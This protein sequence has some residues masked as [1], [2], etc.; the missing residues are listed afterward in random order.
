MLEDAAKGLEP[1]TR[2]LFEVCRMRQIPIFTFINK[3]DR[4]GRDPLS[5]LDEIESEL[6]LTPWAVNWPIGSGEQFRGVIDRR[7]RE[8]ILFTRAA[9]GRQSEER[10]LALN[11]PELSDLVE[12]ELLEQAVE[13]LELLEALCCVAIIVPSIALFIYLLPWWQAKVAVGLVY[14]PTLYLALGSRFILGLHY[15]SH[16]PM[17][18][19]W[20]ADVPYA[21]VLQ[22]IPGLVIAP[23]FGIPSGFYYLHHIAMHHRENNVS[24]RGHGAGVG[25]M[26]SAVVAMRT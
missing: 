18:S 19:V 21:S 9:R 6:E 1:Q 4:P 15:W 20:K 23:F 10:H 2:K 14:I 7:S 8:V 11:D 16:S 17:G 3:M 25:L 5:L 22:A 13:D 12:S 26:P 24:W